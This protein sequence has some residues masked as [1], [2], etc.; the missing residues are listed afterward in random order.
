M[1][2]TSTVRVVFLG[3]SSS[4]VAS[5][6]KLESSFLGVGKSMLKMAGFTTVAL[7]ITVALKTMISD[8]IA[9]QAAMRD[10]NEVAGAAAATGREGGR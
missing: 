8:T 7:G 6:R 3:D 10:V 1:S 9:F 4:A 2:E 5:N